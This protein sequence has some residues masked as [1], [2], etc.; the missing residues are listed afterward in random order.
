MLLQEKP[1]NTME[2]AQAHSED[3]HIQEPSKQRQRRVGIIDISS[4]K[5]TTE[6]ERKLFT[7]ELVALS[8]EATSRDKL[9]IFGKDIRI[10][11]LLKTSALASTHTDQDSNQ[12]WREHCGAMSKKLSSH[13]ATGGP[14]SDLSSMNGFFKDLNALSSVLIEKTPLRKRSSLRTSWKSLPYFLP[15]IMGSDHIGV[16]RGTIARK[17]DGVLMEKIRTIANAYR[18]LY[19][20]ESKL[21][22]KEYVD[23]GKIMSG[24]TARN[25]ALCRLG[26]EPSSE[27][28][29]RRLA[30]IVND[31]PSA[32]IECVHQHVTG[33]Y[34]SALS[35]GHEISRPFL[36]KKKDDI[37]MFRISSNGWSMKNGGVSILPKLLGLRGEIGVF[38]EHDYE[39]ITR[40][41]HI[42]TAI[43][44]IV[45]KRAYIDVPVVQRGVPNFSQR[46]TAFDP[47]LRSFIVTASSS[48]HVREYGQEIV[49]LAREATQRLLARPP[50]IITDE[51]SN[52][53]KRRLSMQLHAVDRLKAKT[54]RRINDMHRKLA[55]FLAMT[56]RAIV[57]SEIA[58]Y[59]ARSQKGYNALQQRFINHSNF[60]KCLKEAC[61]RYGCLYLKTAEYHTSSCCSQCNAG[62][63]SPGDTKVYEC[64]M[65]C[66]HIDRDVN[67]ARNIL[68]RFMALTGK[69]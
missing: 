30:V 43:I 3:G 42:P 46:I 7:H 37:C 18:L 40:S 9:R 41:V 8:K 5:V 60:V 21:V 17:K 29:E 2:L 62:Y 6:E 35:N 4:R 50:P 38:T 44:K 61:S 49:S 11:S 63:Y 24:M 28:H 58:L 25:I 20:M 47:G 56:N 57:S 14:G 32:C 45:G 51:M 54:D 69:Y 48:S 1:Q 22:Y 36:M 10:T 67:G 52:R 26:Y 31:L 16:I 34:R 66:P 23:T 59:L 53:M 13:I 12:S 33:N 15:S 39:V 27:R 65:G 19:N 55:K 68:M 64:P